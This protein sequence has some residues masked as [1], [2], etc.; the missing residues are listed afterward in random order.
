MTELELIEHLNDTVAFNLFVGDDYGRVAWTINPV[1]VDDLYSD[2]GE[3]SEPHENDGQNHLNRRN[4]L[5][6]IEIPWKRKQG[7]ST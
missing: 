7:Q 4:S 1:T 6:Q 3:S 5:L 2:R